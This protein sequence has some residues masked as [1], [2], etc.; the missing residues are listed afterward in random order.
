M[1]CLSLFVY[2]ALHNLDIA[3]LLPGEVERGYQGPGSSSTGGKFNVEGSGG[4]RCRL[5]R[6]E[7]G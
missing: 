7:R 6:R 3:L 1:S 4:R 5:W 2:Q